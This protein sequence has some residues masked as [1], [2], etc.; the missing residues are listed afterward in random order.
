MII[1]KMSTRQA[2]EKELFSA[3]EAGDVD[4]VRR[5]IAAGVDPKNAINKAGIFAGRTPLHTACRY[6]HAV[7]IKF[8]CTFNSNYDLLL[9]S[10]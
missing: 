1:Q 2:V 8:V 9:E 6:V 4:R 3:C 10:F 7:A 5:A